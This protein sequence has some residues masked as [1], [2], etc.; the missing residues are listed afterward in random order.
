MAGPVVN[1]GN[2]EKTGLYLQP[3]WQ[4]TA[5]FR[6]MLSWMEKKEPNFTYIN[7]KNWPKFWK[8]LCLGVEDS[9]MDAR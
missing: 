4:N 9:H 5:L 7:F 8:L 3:S 6:I 2:C 1:Y